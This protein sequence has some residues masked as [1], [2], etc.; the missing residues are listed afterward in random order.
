M[1]CEKKYGY[2]PEIQKADIKENVVELVYDSSK[3]ANTGFEWEN[4]IEV[5]IEETLTMAHKFFSKIV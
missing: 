3:I 5:E 1:I 2:R 4:N